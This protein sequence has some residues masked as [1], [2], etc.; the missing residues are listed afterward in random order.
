MDDHKSDRRVRKTKK[1]LRLALTSLMME[2]TVSEI[3]VREIAD[4]ADVNRG[5]FYAHYKDVSDLLSQVEENV[6][7][8]LGELQ[9]AGDAQDWDAETFR[10]LEDILTLCR[11]NADVYRALI[12]RNN[13][14]AFQQRLT[15]TLK[16]QYLRGF[17]ARFCTAGETARDYY[18]SFI[19]AGMLS[20]TKDWMNSGLRESPAEMARL[21]R[22][23]ILRGAQAMR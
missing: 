4:L 3:T 18:C 9:V 17:L 6:F 21:G 16:N 12:C 23:F 22:D 10:Y 13:D 7:V 8:R 20:I 15:E 5:T 1:Q 19:V 2:K 14:M 11:D